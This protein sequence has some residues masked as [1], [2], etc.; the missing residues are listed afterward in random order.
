[1]TQQKIS[2]L[3]TSQGHLSTVRSQTPVLQ[4]TNLLGSE[5]SQAT[6]PAS[7]PAWSPNSGDLQ[8]KVRYGTGTHRDG[9]YFPASKGLE[10]PLQTPATDINVQFGLS[11]KTLALCFHVHT[12]SKFTTLLKNSTWAAI[13]SPSRQSWMWFSAPLLTTK[14][15]RCH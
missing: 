5:V 1:M 11:R 14:M 10:G 13:S 8:G 6:D 3:Q 2:S 15:G 7:S 9:L 4:G 12:N